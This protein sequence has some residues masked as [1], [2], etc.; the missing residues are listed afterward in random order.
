M[1]RLSFKTQFKIEFLVKK[2]LKKTLLGFLSVWGVVRWGFKLF[3]QKSLDSKP[4][5][6]TC[7]LHPNT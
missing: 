5:S 2:S 6:A 3:G 7:A 1:R 4:Y